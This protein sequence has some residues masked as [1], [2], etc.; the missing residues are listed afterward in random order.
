MTQDTQ[1]Q[2]FLEKQEKLE[3]TY[4]IS[5][6]RRYVLD[7]DE[8]IL[9]LNG[10]DHDAIF[11]VVPAGI[12]D[13]ETQ[14]W[15]WGWDCWDL[16]RGFRD[17]ARDF[18]QLPGEEFAI[19]NLKI[20]EKRAEELAA[21]C[22]EQIG[23][24]GMC[25]LAWEE[26]G[27]ALFCLLLRDAAVGSLQKTIHV[28]L[29]QTGETREAGEDLFAAFGRARLFRHMG[30]DFLL[31]SLLAVPQLLETMTEETLADLADTLYDSIPEDYT[32]EEDSMWMLMSRLSKLGKVRFFRRL[33]AMAKERPAGLQ[34]ICHIGMEL[35]YAWG[36]GHYREVSRLLG[37][38]LLQEEPQELTQLYLGVHG[39]QPG[40]LWLLHKECV[41]DNPNGWPLLYGI[42]T[43]VLT[44]SDQDELGYH[45]RRV[46]RFL[47]EMD[48][49][50]QGEPFFLSLMEQPVLRQAALQ[51]AYTRL[52]QGW[53]QLTMGKNT[54]DSVCAE[55]QA[56]ARRWLNDRDRERLPDYDY[57]K[58]EICQNFLEEILKTEDKLELNEQAVDCLTKT[59]AYVLTQ[60]DPEETG[61]RP[62]LTLMKRLYK[63][64]CL[65]FFQQYAQG[66]WADVEF[67]EQLSLGFHGKYRQ[68][69]A[70]LAR[71]LLAN[72]DQARY[73]ERRYLLGIY[74]EAPEYAK[75]IWL[76]DLDCISSDP[77]AQNVHGE[78]LMT[79]LEDMPE[80]HP[81][82]D[83]VMAA[84]DRFLRTLAQS[85]EA[86]A[87]ALWEVMAQ[88]LADTCWSMLRCYQVYGNQTNWLAVYPGR[89]DLY[90][91][92]C[93]QFL[94]TED[95]RQRYR[96]GVVGYLQEDL[97][98]DRESAD[99][100]ALRDKLLSYVPE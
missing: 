86:R 4:Q 45:R 8:G 71:Y 22:L 1:M 10:W 39:Y 35:S 82:H 98:L 27:Q 66:Q 56:F 61:Y 23:G 57:R 67:A 5:Q 96:L 13:K 31:S 7:Q 85:G 47:M 21:V 68:M 83:W 44:H 40:S 78:I 52:H 30:T 62:E 92:A 70:Y 48:E 93:A 28:L 91:A 29:E 43:A 69:A 2:H 20:T 49:E 88:W 65:A 11:E 54:V 36:K 99:Y 15:Q 19:G 63:E 64:K 9:R 18:A 90:Q 17:K 94:R 37:R 53:D 12:Y 97:G 95:R 41:L 58:M 16:H 38:L 46:Y 60:S 77:A 34:R 33:L 76:M 75:A 84:L 26:P 51:A 55:F 42:M 32:E 89:S 24:L 74:G 50:K 72:L 79:I 14:S 87:V 6:C 59:V 25:R 73:M 3:Q 81:D 100:P 80:D